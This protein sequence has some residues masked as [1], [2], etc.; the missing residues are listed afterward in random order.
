MAESIVQVTEG[1]GKKLHTF[2]RTIGAN[3]VEDEIVVQGESYLPALA[4]ASEGAVSIATAASHPLQIMAGASNKCRI[5]R[6]MVYQAGLAT[7]AA[8]ASFEIRR[9][10][11]AGTGGTALSADYLEP[12]DTGASIAGMSLPTVK[13]TEGGVRLWLGSYTMMQTAP[14]AGGSALM[15]DIDFDKLMRHKSLIIAAGVANG[16]CLKNITAIAAA[17]IYYVVYYTETT[18]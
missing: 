3:N 7:A 13:G 2:Q 14:T 5:R 11:T 17:T 16:I 10:T 9:L 1:V 18:F 8:I 12:G 4:I 15:F 6:I